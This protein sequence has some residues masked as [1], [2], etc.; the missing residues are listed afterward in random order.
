[1]LFRSLLKQW[2]LE[3][4]RD[5]ALAEQRQRIIVAL[6]GADE[7]HGA[8]PWK[9]LRD[10]YKGM[11]DVQRI[12]ARTALRQVRPRE[13]VALG[14]ALQRAENLRPLLNAEAALQNVAQHLQTPPGLAEL[15]QR[16]LLSEPA[17]LV[18]DG[19]VINHG[20]DAELDELRA[21]QNN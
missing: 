11:S 4:P 2:L 13:L 21:I 20:Y 8:G 15:L 17:A 12:S 1:M 5:R 9:A 19:G 3:P 10:A 16:A 6:Q 7:R 18:R 14:L